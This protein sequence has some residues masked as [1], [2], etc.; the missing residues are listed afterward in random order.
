MDPE[1]YYIKQKFTL[2]AWKSIIDQK[3]DESSPDFQQLKLYQAQAY[4]ALNK[5]TEALKL[6]DPNNTSLS[7]RALRALAR[8]LSKEGENALEELRDLCVEIEEEGIDEKE[9]SLV[10]VAAG[11]AFAREGEIEEALETLGAGTGVENLDTLALV[12]Q[13]YLSINRVDLAKRECDR[14]RKWAED[15]LLLQHIEASIGLL[16]GKDS[17]SNPHSFYVEQLNNPSLSSGHL[18]VSRGVTH[19]LRGELPEAQSDFAQAQKPEYGD[20]ADALAGAVVAAELAGHKANVADLWS[21]LSQEYPDH[22]LT[23]SVLEKDAEFDSFASKYEVPPLAA[24][25]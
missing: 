21:K 4:I 24:S 3:L 14:A 23:K 5:P 8:Y 22:P 2:G 18:L 1:L 17:Y 25:A 16:T 15:D 13:I 19:L 20:P 10:K 12:V 11:T 6:L 7:V 9:K